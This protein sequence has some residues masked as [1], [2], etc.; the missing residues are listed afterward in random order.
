MIVLAERISP[1]RLALHR[2]CEET[3]DPNSYA[4]YMLL[5]RTYE[6]EDTDRKWKYDWRYYWIARRTF[7]R[8]K[9]KEHGGFWV[10]HYC[11]KVIDEKNKITVDHKIPKT[12]ISD[13][14]DSTNFVESCS[15]CNGQ[16]SGMHYNDYVQR[17]GGVPEI[18]K[19]LTSFNILDFLRWKLFVIFN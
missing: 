14:T 11:G 3:P 1:R 13:P 5:K 15:P 16:K 19:Q 7:L 2:I 12:C 6:N 9:K 4:A 8:N 17:I 18:E 10:C